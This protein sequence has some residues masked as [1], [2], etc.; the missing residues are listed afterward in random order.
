MLILVQRN[1]RQ[2]VIYSYRLQLVKNSEVN[3]L[4][5]QKC[6]WQQSNTTTLLKVRILDKHVGLIS[7]HT[8]Q[9]R[10][11]KLKI[12][13]YKIV[14]VQ[15]LKSCSITIFHR[16]L[17]NHVILISPKSRIVLNSCS[18]SL[19]WICGILRV[20]LLVCLYVNIDILVALIRQPSRGECVK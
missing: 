2:I 17:L 15:T 13:I 11:G 1:Q 7:I 14:L 3:R 19:I 20:V 10:T 9:V 16:E 18:V 6:Q 5:Q 8:E 12:L 4:R